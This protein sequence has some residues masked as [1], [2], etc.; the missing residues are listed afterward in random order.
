M[1]IHL[2]FSRKKPHRES[3]RSINSFVNVCQV[4]RGGAGLRG[5]CPVYGQQEMIG[6]SFDLWGSADP[7]LTDAKR[8]GA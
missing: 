3:T 2:N 1:V 7:S 5:K 4:R 8:P 6:P